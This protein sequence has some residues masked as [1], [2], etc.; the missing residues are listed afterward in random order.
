MPLMISILVSPCHIFFVN[1]NIIIFV[2]FII[3]ILLL[4]L[5]LFDGK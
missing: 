2:C 3:T 1:L 5:I 4:D